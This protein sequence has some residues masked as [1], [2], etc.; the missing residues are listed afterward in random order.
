VE[1]TPKRRSYRILLRSYKPFTL[2]STLVHQKIK[3]NCKQKKTINMGN[4]ATPVMMVILLISPGAPAEVAAILAMVAMLVNKE[5]AAM[6]RPVSMAAVAVLLLANPR[7][8]VTLA[9]VAAVIANQGRLSMP[10]TAVAQPVAL[11]VLLGV[12]ANLE[13][14]VIAL[15]A[16]LGRPM[17]TLALAEAIVVVVA[18]PG[19]LTMTS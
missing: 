4:P 1:G 11:A 10:T 2:C 5:V 15:L 6:A 7:R 13:R 3:T 12:L 17:M 9:A 19:S 18:N 16:N 8:L 14:L